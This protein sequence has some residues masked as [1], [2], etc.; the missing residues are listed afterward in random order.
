MTKN[1]LICCR[2]LMA[3]GQR[4]ELLVLAS[5]TCAALCNLLD[6]YGEQIRRISA[7]V[8]GLQA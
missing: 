3:D 7:S 4:C 6:A 8:V 1:R 5:G 2:C